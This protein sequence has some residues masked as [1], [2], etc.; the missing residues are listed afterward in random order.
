MIGGKTLVER[1]LDVVPEAEVRE[2]IVVLG[3]EADAVAAA[4][5]AWKGVRVVVNADYRAGM[6]TSIR[7]GVLSLARDTEGVLVLLADQPFVTRSLL[8]RMLKAFEGERTKDKIVAA[9]YG[10]VVTPPAIFPRTYFRE[11]SEL[12][13]DRGARS[14]IQ[15]HVGSLLL[16]RVRARHILADVDTRE[17]FEAA[18]RLLEP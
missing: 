17:E 11:L 15:R 5:R 2:T 8:V 18:R 9:A 14:V 4:V 1:A 3:H 12:G 7:A 6:S 16:V 13:G 10:D